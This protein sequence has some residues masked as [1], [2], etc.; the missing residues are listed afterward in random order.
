MG[1]IMYLVSRVAR[2]I[3]FGYTIPMSKKILIDGV[4]S[5]QHPL[6]NCWSHMLQRCNNPNNKD[7][8]NYGGRGIKVYPK[9]HNSANF[10]NDM[11]D[12]YK[13]GLTIDRIDSNKGYYP[14]NCRWADSMTQNHNRRN[15]RNIVVNGKK[16][17]FSDL[18]KIHGVSYQVIMSRFWAG[19]Y[20]PEEL[21]AGKR[22]IIREKDI[23]GKFTGR[24]QVA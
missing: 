8:P 2:T 21:L 4:P 19:K 5:R 13:K 24:T 9:W 23:E 15:S 18:A 3:I 10:I 14:S 1:L 7:Y 20:T 22:I 17:H 16:Y 11:K 6:Y 12:T